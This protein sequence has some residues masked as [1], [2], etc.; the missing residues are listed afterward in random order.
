MEAYIIR[1]YRKG[2]DQAVSAVIKA[3][4]EEYGFPWQPE[5]YNADTQD[6]ETHYIR[7]RGE[8]WVAE[9]NGETIG[10]GGYLPLD[11]TQCELHRLYFLQQHRGKGVGGRML[12]TIAQA[13]LAK[14]F[15][16]MVFWSDKVLT[17]AHRVYEAM[18]AVCIGDR[19]VHD[20]DYASYDEWGF[21]LELA[22]F[23]SKF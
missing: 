1:P 19:H 22:P 13:A 6:I 3:V 11:E 2:D 16:K 9:I 23:V 15:V 18:G 4:F 12:R 17:T 7:K 20:P 8:F 21:E 14:G 10:A 5:R